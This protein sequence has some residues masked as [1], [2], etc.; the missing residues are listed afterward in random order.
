MKRAAIVGILAILAALAAPAARADYAVLRSGE[1]LRITGYE[2]LGPT[3]R[4]TIVGGSIEIPASELDRIEPEEIFTPAPAPSAQQTKTPYA[5]EIAAAALRYGVDPRLV[6]AV[7]AAESNFDPR[8]VSARL[9]CGLMQLRPEVVSRYRVANVF[10]PKQNIEAGTRY[11]KELL[12]R[13]GQNL[14]LA[15]AAY[16]AG[17]DRVG[18]YGGI[19]PFPETLEYVRRVTER[20]SQAENK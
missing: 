17:P 16:N 19:P 14:S 3:V 13:Y 15:L 1:R 7:I 10:D 18:Q 4:L 8:A 20:Y 6:T 5:G 2:T 9:A 11:L 12:D